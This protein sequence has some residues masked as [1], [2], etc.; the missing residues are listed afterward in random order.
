[1]MLGKKT[2]SKFFSLLPLL[3]GFSINISCLNY[4]GWLAC[5]SSCMVSFHSCAD[6]YSSFSSGNLQELYERVKVGEWA[7]GTA[8]IRHCHFWDTALVPGVRLWAEGQSVPRHLL[9]KYLPGHILGFALC[10]HSADALS[11]CS[12]CRAKRWQWQGQERQGSCF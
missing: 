4:S 6:V 8:N 11:P 10:E 5:L 7:L 2:K 9:R 3:V 1:M 12:D